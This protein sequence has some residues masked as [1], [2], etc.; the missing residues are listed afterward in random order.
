MRRFVFAKM[1]VDIRVN[2]TAGRDTEQGPMDD[3][4]RLFLPGEEKGRLIPVGDVVSD[5]SAMPT[6]YKVGLVRASWGVM[7]LRSP[8]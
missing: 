5:G 1:R 4:G 6:S 3:K 2:V 7:T 8:L